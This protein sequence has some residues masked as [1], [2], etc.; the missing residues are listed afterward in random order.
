MTTSS[1]HG[2]FQPAPAASD[3][4]RI[5][6]RKSARRLLPR[7]A[8]AVRNG[9][10][11]VAALND[12][13][14]FAF[15]AGIHG[16]PL[17]TWCVH[18]GRT[19]LPWHR[20]YLYLFELALQDQVPQAFLPWWDWSSD[21]SHGEGIPSLYSKETLDDGTANPLYSQPIPAGIA[22]G[23]P[24]PHLTSRDPGDPDGLPTRQDV[25]D[26]LAAGD[27]RDFTNRVENLHN[28][29]HVWMGGTMADIAYAAYDPLFWAHHAMVDRLWRLW[30]LNHTG[31]G[32][33]DRDLL[34]AALSPFPMTVRMTL[35]VNALGYDYAVFTSRTDV[36][37]EEDDPA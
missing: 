6:H 24:Q 29:V 12:E 16:L 9:Y 5:R 32:S 10:R 17:P 30:E 19:F 26:V 25:E 3:R 8:E 28:W 11:A 2:Q 21:R 33:L 27:F 22:N 13:R 14:G 4:G 15:H 1:W 7:Q 36:G 37:E 31:V 34:D 20:A 23:G 18:G 35:E